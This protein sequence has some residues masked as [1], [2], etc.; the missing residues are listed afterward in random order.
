[1]RAAERDTSVSAL[2]KAF[3]E[4]LEKESDFERL[5]RRER[6]LAAAITHFDASDRLS[7]DQLHERRK[8]R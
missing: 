1:M 8:V 6:E 5:K 2:V 4:S 7:R 3:F